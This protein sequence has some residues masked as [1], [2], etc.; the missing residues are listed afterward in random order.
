[1]RG[2][3]RWVGVLIVTA[4]ASGL[5]AA[6][7]SATAAP[8]ASTTA[9][10][11]LAPTEADRAWERTGLPED[12]R[13]EIEPVRLVSVFEQPEAIAACLRAAGYPH[14]VAAHGKVEPGEI[15]EEHAASFALSTYVCEAQFPTDPL[16]DRPLSA[17]QIRALFRYRSTEQRECLQAL[18]HAIAIPPTEQEFVSGYPEHGGWNPLNNVSAYGFAAAV[19]ACPPIPAEF[20]P[21]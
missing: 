9:G 20:D 8:P 6:C 13:H 12:Q 15:A 1:M 14:V 5:L 16:F 11:D 10:G 18:G 21:R 7:A 4:A 3:R 19:E 2:H 17:D